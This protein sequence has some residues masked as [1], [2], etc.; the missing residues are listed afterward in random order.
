MSSEP[1]ATALGRTQGLSLRPLQQETITMSDDETNKALGRSVA[2]GFSMHEIQHQ[3]ERTTRRN[4]TLMEIAAARA[5][6][7]II[8]IDEGYEDRSGGA[9]MNAPSC[10]G[11]LIIEIGAVHE[12][13]T[14]E[15]PLGMAAGATNETVVGRDN[16]GETGEV[17]IRVGEGVASQGRR[18]RRRRRYA[19][20][21][22]PLEAEPRTPRMP[23]SNW[24]DYD[25]LRES[26]FN[27]NHGRH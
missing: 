12:A 20:G 5:S 4:Q 7:K 9:Q 15:V 2:D 23:L 21:F 6:N 10:D 17:Q 14:G 24:E 1:H 27:G 11:N 3:M 16:R 18:R 13:G 8:E 19:R 26:F 22:W 25:L